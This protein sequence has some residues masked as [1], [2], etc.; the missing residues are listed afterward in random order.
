MVLAR[1]PLPRLLWLGQVGSVAGDRLYSVALIWVTVRLTGSAGAVAL[2][3]LA[4][5]LQFLVV[6]I[7]SGWIADSR[8]ALRLIRLATA[9]G[10]W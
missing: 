8:D 1:R 5:T 6:S 2:V 9:P 10:P 7:F 3:M 4:D